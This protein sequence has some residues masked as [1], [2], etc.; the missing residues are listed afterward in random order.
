VNHKFHMTCIFVLLN[1]VCVFPSTIRFI[2]KGDGK[3]CFDIVSLCAI[4][5]IVS[6]GRLTLPVS[7]K[8]AA[9][10]SVKLLL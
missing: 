1:L 9:V 2:N 5:F 6:V 7:L 10:C 8:M 4:F 3:F